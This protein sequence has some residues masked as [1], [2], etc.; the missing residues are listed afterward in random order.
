MPDMEKITVIDS[1]MGPWKKVMQRYMEGRLRPGDILRQR[2]E[3][4]NHAQSD[5]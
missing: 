5:R 3:R 1:L 4:T 2:P